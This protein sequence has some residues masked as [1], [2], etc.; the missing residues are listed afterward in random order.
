MSG[1]P[2]VVGLAAVVFGVLFAVVWKT[3]LKKQPAIPETMMTDSGPMMLVPAGRF[4]YAEDRRATIVPAF[5]VDRTEVTNQAYGQF[6]K[7][8]GRALPQGFPGDK[9]GDP[10]VNVTFT[11]ANAFAKWSGK[12][13]PNAQEWEK[14]ARGTD[15]RIYPWGNDADPLKANVAGSALSAAASFFESESPFHTVNMAGNAREWVDD[16]MVP[17]P[18]DLARFPGSTTKE[19]WRIVRG[20]SFRRPLAEAVVW[21][22]E[23]A[24]VGYL[25]ADAG[26]RCVRSVQ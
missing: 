22:W 20:G 10:V 6:C 23:A 3:P 21:K 18:A 25:A 13:L 4:L 11:D 9:A 17:G 24:P 14:A 12:R 5:Y 7:A 8:T 2:V 19:E 1:K 15:G 26:F 16:Q